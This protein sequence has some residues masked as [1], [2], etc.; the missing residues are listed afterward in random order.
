MSI[1][2]IRFPRRNFV[3]AI[4]RASI[5]SA[6]LV[7]VSAGAT[8]ARAA[9]SLNLPQTFADVK[10]KLAAGGQ[11]NIVVLGDSLSFD[12]T[13]G[14][15]RYFRDRM[16]A[17]YG[18]AGPGYYGLAPAGPEGY[19]TGWEA[20]SI[21]VDAVPHRAIDGLWV[22]APASN[23]P[24]VPGKS[25]MFWATGALH[26]VAEPGGGKV[27]VRLWDGSGVTLDTSAAQTEVRTWSYSITS[28]P[29]A[30]SALTFTPLGD[31][32]VTLLGQNLT[33]ST[34]GVRVHRASNGGWGVQNYLQRD[35]TFD[36]QLGLL[37]SDLV[38]V[39]LGANDLGRWTAAEFADKTNQLI[40][41]IHAAVPQAKIALVSSYDVGSDRLPAQVAAMEQVAA[42]RGVGFINLYEVAGS[43]AFFQQ[44]NYLSD[45]VHFNAAGADYVGKIVYDAFTTDGASLVPEP[46]AI[47]LLALAGCAAL[48]RR[49]RSSAAA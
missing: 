14:W 43:H 13:N 32:R 30:N 3:A 27:D 36:Q 48:R 7:M 22:S 19:G 37:D 9:T 16:Q 1:F 20:G 45:T 25:D 40:D 41:R 47:G 23:P 24:A 44:S 2:Q 11:A 10:T 26:Y 21:G 38:M 17:R 31:G 42:D 35:V 33:N 28:G 29:N 18:N 12:E 39:A 6:A 49:R 4:V 5:G 15:R 8:A 34:P 46:S